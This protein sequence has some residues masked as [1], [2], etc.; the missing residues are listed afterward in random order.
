MKKVTILM[1]LGLLILSGFL[2]SA[3]DTKAGVSIKDEGQRTNKR[4]VASGKSQV[5]S[6]KTG[7]R[8]QG[9]GFDTPLNPPSKGD[10]EHAARQRRKIGKLRVIE[11][12]KAK[13]KGYY[14][15]RKSTRLNSSHIPLSR[16][17]SS[18]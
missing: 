7:Y 13:Y 12:G 4:A 18:A 2:Y 15:D 16:M 1:M 10:L 3:N 9:V 17:P 6:E 11:R 14:L 5:I 8:V